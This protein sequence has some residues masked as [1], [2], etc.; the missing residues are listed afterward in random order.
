[1]AIYILKS[2]AC[3]AVFLVFY[4]L[5]LEKE[6]MH[7]FKRFYLLVSV[8]ASLLIPTIVFMEYV[9]VNPVS[10]PV[11]T[12]PQVNDYNFI[13]EP[14]AIKDNVTDF[15]PVFG[16]VYFLGLI[17]FSFRFI[18]NLNQII[19]RIIRNPKK[20]ATGFIHVLLKENFP[21]HTFFKYIFLNKN[22]SEANQIPIEVLLHEETHAKQRH[23]YDIVFIELVQVVFWFNPLIILFKKAI[24]LNHEFLADQAVLKKEIDQPTYQNTLLSYL[25][26]NSYNNYQSKMANAINYSS[27]KNRF[28]VMKKTTTKK[29]IFLRTLLLLP[30]TL[31]LVFGF[32][33]TKVVQKV[34]SQNSIEGVWLDANTETYAFSILSNGNQ[35]HFNGL[36]Y[37]H[38]I[39]KFGQEY[40]VTTEYA[41]LPISLESETGLLSFSGRN[42]VLK[43]N[44]LRNQFEGNWKSI[45]GDITLKV[46]NYTD[47]FI[48]AITKDG[49]TNKFYP[50]RDEDGFFFTY[51][52]ENWSFK[53]ENG[54]LI[55]SKG[56]T[57][58]KEVLPDTNEVLFNQ[59]E[60]SSLST[61]ELEEY[62]RLATKL[63]NNKYGQSRI[64][65]SEIETMQR[66]YQKMTK[67]EKL[68]SVERFGF[69]TGS[70]LKNRKELPQKQV[71]IYN[72]LAKKYNSIPIENR[73]IPSYALKALEVNYRQMTLTQK[74]RAQPF[75]DYL[76][77][78]IQ[79]GAS[80]EQMAIYNALAKK[81]NE[82]SKD[83]MHIKMKEVERMKYIYNLM[84][85]KQRADAEPFPELPE[86]P[87][88]P[89]TPGNPE[90]PKTIGNGNDLPPP[91][92]PPTPP[93]PLD[94]VI[95][96][97]K[98]GADFYYEG[99]KISSDKAIELLKKNKSLNIDSRSN[100][101]NNPVVRISKAPIKVGLSSEKETNIY[102]Y[103]RELNEKGA[104]FYLHGEIIEAELALYIIQN[105]DFEKVET[106]PW[107]NKKPEVKILSKS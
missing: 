3:M 11:S 14:K 75:P 89:Q 53:I 104:L 40:Y 67:E 36:N 2:I 68:A 39:E 51:G 88:P 49:Q 42:Y 70:N 33:E 46:E 100:N 50:K 58:S 87:P 85:E 38:P 45:E 69:P 64:L 47:G 81:Y 13:A 31:L 107:I 101:S 96:M 59:D 86:P 12:E 6:N 61:E 72:K 93:S 20:K 43:E 57:Y 24:K 62:N 99:K 25:S 76:P 19:R 73:I 78:N 84:S 44:S 18:R 9:V 55:D 71:N 95:E 32:S 30:L 74:E 7:V 22:K 52:H 41:D 56:M 21:P 97:A 4:K 17:Y 65:V 48:W 103:S 94:H 98:K 82:M 83:N 37:N 92:P 77:D 28:T 60:N 26:N 54:D 10:L 79:K 5:L 34:S 80:R 1:M 106:Y 16:F 27:I 66:L 8:I 15:S 29:S 91:P 63:K 23:S 35:L 102:K 90:P 105:R